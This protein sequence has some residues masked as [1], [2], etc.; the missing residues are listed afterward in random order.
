MAEEPGTGEHFFSG[1]VGKMR[2]LFTT[3][4]EAGGLGGTGHSGAEKNHNYVNLHS[5][6]KQTQIFA[7]LF[8]C[9]L[10]DKNCHLKVVPSLRQIHASCRISH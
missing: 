9:I 6:F 1:L 2:G 4:P 5:E 3:A 8:L 10:R 7:I